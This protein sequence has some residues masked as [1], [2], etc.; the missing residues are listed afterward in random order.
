MES[1]NSL[2][3]PETMVDQRLQVNAGKTVLQYYRT[4]TYKAINELLAEGGESYYNYVKS[5]GLIKDP[6]LVVLSS[7]HHY[8]FDNE[9]L[10]E[11][12]TIINLKQLNLIKDLDL[13]FQ[14]IF[15]IMPEN[16]NY[17]GCFHDNKRQ[18]K[19]AVSNILSQYHKRNNVDPFENGIISRIPFLNTV[20]NLMDSKTSKSL[21]AEYVTLFLEKQGFEVLNMTDI[22]GLT[23]FHAHK[24]RGYRLNIAV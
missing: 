4:G 8:Y 20:Y 9:D 3:N 22:K 14:S 11:T 5:L 7:V 23:Y 1:L 13:H 17:I 24:T 6:D 21:T 2:R 19:Y 12:N 15:K 16:S 18:N 10:K